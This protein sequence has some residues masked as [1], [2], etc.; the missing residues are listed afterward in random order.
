MLN[1]SLDRSE[2]L[3]LY[4]GGYVL[5][6]DYAIGMEYERLPISRT[7]FK[8]V[9]YWGENGVCSLL[10]KFARKN[11]WDYIVDQNS[12]IGLA[13]GHD[14]ITLEPGAQI[15]I[16]SKPEKTIFRLKDKIDILN[17]KFEELLD[18]TDIL[19]LSYG[20][21]PYSTCKSINLIPKRRYKI[22]AN[23]L[24]GILSDVMMR[25]TAGIQVG[26]D[27]SSEE[28]AMRKFR[29]ANLMMPFVTAMYANSKI[30]GGVDTGYKSFRALSWLNC[31]NERCGFATGF[32]DG[33]TFRSYIDKVLDTPMIFI[34]RENRTVSLNGRLTFRQFMKEG[35]EGFEADIDDWKLHANLFFPEVRLRN[36]IEIRNHDCVGNGLEYSIPAFY[37]GIMYNSDSL[38]EVEKILCKFSSNQINELRYNVARYA[39]NAK[40]SKYTAADICRELLM[41][42]YQGLTAQYTDEEDYLNPVIE[43]IKNNKIP[44]DI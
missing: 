2:I 7:S 14:T 16:S 38:S 39:I 41:I 21:S 32:N 15:E 44:A 30:R 22:M 18:G 27:F 8:T 31:D 35:Y 25:E 1:L 19:F 11:G 42:A 26:I 28:D 6:E 36:F 43:L 29:V 17:S 9:D 5:P 40:I 37:K 4:T 3:K 10:E 23:Y 24:W 20:V 12:I 34:N 13:K 33:I